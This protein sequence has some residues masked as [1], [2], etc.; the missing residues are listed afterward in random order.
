MTTS[1][2]IPVKI[3]RVQNITCSHVFDKLKKEAA[4]VKASLLYREVTKTL[5]D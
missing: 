5:T 1:D 3:I 4:F 2:I